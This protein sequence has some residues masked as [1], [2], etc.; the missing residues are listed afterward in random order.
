MKGPRAAHPGGRSDVRDHF[1]E[2]GNLKHP[3]DL[4]GK[5]AY[6]A[7]SRMMKNDEGTSAGGPSGERPRP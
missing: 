7:G 4:S 6:S 2:D 1:D 5:A 3:K